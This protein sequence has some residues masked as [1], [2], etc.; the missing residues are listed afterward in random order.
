V[1]GRATVRFAGAFAFAAAGRAA[2]RAGAFAGVVFVVDT[3][4]A[5]A[6]FFAAGVAFLSFSLSAIRPFSP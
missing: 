2:G 5:G 6:A 4:F 1:T 3:A